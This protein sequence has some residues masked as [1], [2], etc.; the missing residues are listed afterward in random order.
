MTPPSTQTKTRELNIKDISPY[1]VLRLLTALALLGLELVAT[2]SQT[3]A[4]HVSLIGF[5]V[6]LLSLFYIA[7][8]SQAVLWLIK[9]I[10]RH[11]I[12]QLFDCLNAKMALGLHA[13]RRLPL[14]Y[15]IRNLHVPHLQT[16]YGI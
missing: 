6:R 11:L 16:L 7:S 13:T 15:N 14:C 9:D 1:K 3:Q 2:H 8:S 4:I 5:Y 10:C 12:N